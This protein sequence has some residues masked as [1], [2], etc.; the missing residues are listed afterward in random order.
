MVVE[1]A[2]RRRDSGDNHV[3]VFVPALETCDCITE[4]SEVLTVFT[5]SLGESSLSEERA[6]L[7]NALPPI[8]P[9]FRLDPP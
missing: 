6:T 4:G 3:R 9:S 2:S 5:L 8:L 7:D 1:I